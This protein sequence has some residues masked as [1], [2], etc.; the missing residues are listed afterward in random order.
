MLL[1]LSDVETSILEADKKE[2]ASFRVEGRVSFS[3]LGRKMAY[4]KGSEILG[5]IGIF[6]R[7]LST[8]TVVTK[9]IF[10]IDENLSS[11][12]TLQFCSLYLYRECNKFTKNIL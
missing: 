1:W 10:V 8:F 7:R 6:T 5:R 11:P 12:L 2:A 3:R 4:I 9:D